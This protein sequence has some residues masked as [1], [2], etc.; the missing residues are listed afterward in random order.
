M[1]FQVRSNGSTFVAEKKRFRVRLQL[2]G[3]AHNEDYL[4]SN[5]RDKGRENF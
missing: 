1:V 3:S 2:V 4:I 5:N